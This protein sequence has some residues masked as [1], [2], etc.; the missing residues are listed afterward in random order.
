MRKASIGCLLILTAGCFSSTL[1]QLPAHTSMKLVYDEEKM[2][3][4]VL[5]YLSI[6]MP[7][8]NAKRIMKDSGFDCDTFSFS[9]DCVT[10]HVYY[11]SHFNTADEIFVRL[12]H[13]DGKLTDVQVNCQCIG[14]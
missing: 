11:E 1:L 6:G 5:H 12:Y 14:P 9:S 3:E 4:E 13:E 10:C 8:A 2:K 7:I